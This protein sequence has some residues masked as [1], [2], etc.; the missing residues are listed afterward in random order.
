MRPIFAKGAA[1]VRDEDRTFLDLEDNWLDLQRVT[2]PVSLFSIPT[3]SSTVSVLQQPSVAAHRHHM[4]LALCIMAQMKKCVDI[5]PTFQAAAA[6][7]RL[8]GS[9]TPER[10]PTTPEAIMQV[11]ASTR[12]I[13]EW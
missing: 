7:L 4:G 2:D 12:A 11:K 5:V 3:V 9:T 6:S 10:G 13:H 1:A 8:D